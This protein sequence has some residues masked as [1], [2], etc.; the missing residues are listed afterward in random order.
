[1]RIFPQRHF[2]Y[3]LLPAICWQ[4][5]VTYPGMELG[6][7]ITLWWGNRGIMFVGES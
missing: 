1:M 3:F 7:S 6:W 2:N 5:P 4:P